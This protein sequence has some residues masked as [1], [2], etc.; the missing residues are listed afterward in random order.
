[1]K[2]D[3]NKLYKF[4]FAIGLLYF[5]FIILDVP[6]IE[7][8]WEGYPDVIDYKAQSK[9]SLTSLNFYAT[10]PK[11]NVW[12][13]PRP[14]TV[15]LFF[16][17]ASS[18]SYNMV[19]LQK[20]TY[21]I[22]VISLLIAIL[23]F[24]SHFWVKIIAQC[25]LLFF[26]TWWN[27]VGWS[28][29]PI[30]ESLSISLLFFWFSTILFY[31][32]KQS[33]LNIIFLVIS[34]ILLSFTRDTW[35]YIILLFFLLNIF[36]S[37]F[38]SIG[39]IKKNVSLFV[40]SICLFFAQSY[41]ANVGQR[42]WMPMFNS[43][44]GRVAQHDD[45]LAWF[46][47]EG[48]PEADTLK[49][50]FGEIKDLELDGRVLIS[51]RYCDSTYTNLFLWIMK[52]GKNKYQKFLLTH[53][54]Y[55]FL[56][57]LSSESVRGN[58]FSYNL[59]YYKGSEGF[60]VNADHVFPVFNVWFYL[61]FFLLLLFLF[62]KTKEIVYAFLASVFI[63]CVVN[64]L[65]TY[66]ADALEIKRHLFITTIILEFISISTLI[67]LADYISNLVIKKPLKTL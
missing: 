47:N 44:A 56:Q 20:T 65:I 21:C 60:F 4:L 41:T 34:S 31:Y 32:K 52:D 33:V 63:L 28:D 2:I 48:M 15:P 17:M 9:E 62:F 54:Y 22:C 66:N 11:E 38:L 64:A 61:V 40:F 7:P 13:F 51:K 50:D 5:C 53:P 26:F 49:T 39:S 8:Q 42:H 59:P 67:L 12:F 1:M 46:K 36:I 55:F 45:Y 23:N 16:K 43:I 14:F 58:L 24:I 25:G 30:S 37:I 57:D 6:K 3:R 27:I 18:D 35:P 19:M 29:L 10:K